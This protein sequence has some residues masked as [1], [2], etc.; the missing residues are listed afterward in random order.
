MYVCTM[1]ILRESTNLSH[2]VRALVQ[3]TRLACGGFVLAMR[4]PH[5]MA[6]AQGLVQFLGAVAELARGAATPT[7]QPVWDREMLEARDPPRPTFPHHEYDAVPPDSKQGPIMQPGNDMVHRSFFFGRR[8]VS[9]IRARLPHRLRSRATAFDVITGCL[10][11]CRTA[12]LA[13][14]A[15]AVTRMICVASARGNR[16]SGE[17]G[18]PKG[19]YGNT[20]AFPTA[21]AAA[22]ELRA[23][24]VGFAVE[25]VQRAK[26]GV[27][28]EYLRSVADLMVLRGRP[29]FASANAFLVSDVTRAGFGYL[30]FGWGEPVYGGPAK[31]SVGLFPGMASFL[32][33]T[34]NAD[35]E[36]GAVVPMC[37]PGPAMERFAEEV[38]EIIR[39]PVN[40]SAL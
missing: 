14:H 24:P 32:I 1:A 21:L 15:N 27:D 33:A 22:G 40:K 35:G 9:A 26:R 23:R 7:V 34:K 38:A 4:E 17:P 8:E 19:Y 6:D 11:K 2:T 5:T 20:F 10:W 31:G 29:H 13:P 30:D 39:P 16:R 25:L 12:A 36:H 3:V 37:L 28:V 18:I